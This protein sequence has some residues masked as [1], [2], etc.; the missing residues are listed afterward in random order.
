[1]GCDGGGGTRTRSQGV[2]HFGSTS[3]LWQKASDGRVPAEEDVSAASQHIIS[4]YDK[5]RRVCRTLVSYVQNIT[6]FLLC[7]SV[8]GVKQCGRCSEVILSERRERSFYSPRVREKKEILEGTFHI[9]TTSLLI[10]S[11]RS[12]VSLEKSIH[13]MQ[14]HVKV[15]KKICGGKINDLVF[16]KVEEKK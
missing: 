7:G 9:F 10:T 6:C 16:K 4:V 1:M 13:F 5:T 3:L 11:Q 12:L 14:S 8:A 2:P 15:K